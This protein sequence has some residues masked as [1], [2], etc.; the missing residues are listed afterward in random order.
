MTHKEPWEE[1]ALHELA[2]EADR[3]P[4]DLD[5]PDDLDDDALPDDGWDDPEAQ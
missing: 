2:V 3:D 5:T 1:F 4:D